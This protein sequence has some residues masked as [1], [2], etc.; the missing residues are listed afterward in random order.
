MP[1]KATPP[2]AGREAGWLD[3]NVEKDLLE[4]LN[5]LVWAKP[6]ERGL[7]PSTAQGL[8]SG[9][10]FDHCCWAVCSGDPLPAPRRSGW[11]PEAYVKPLEEAP[12]SPMNP[13][14]PVTPMNLMSP[15]NELPSRYLGGQKWA[16]V[17]TL[18]E[19]GPTLQGD[20]C[21]LQS[22]VG[23]ASFGPWRKGTP[24][25]HMRKSLH[26]SL[27]LLLGLPSSPYGLLWPRY[28]GG[29]CRTP[30]SPADGVGCSRGLTPDPLPVPP[31]SGLRSYP[32]RGSHSLDDLLDRPGNSAAPLEYWDGQARSRTPSRVPSCAPSPAPT[33]LPDSRRSSMGS[34]G[35]ASDV[36]VSPH[37]PVSSPGLMQWAGRLETR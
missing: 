26:P 14:S 22:C 1:P 12:V 27:C 9:V 4:G 35:V 3:L 29:G 11:F 7:A 17:G 2:L 32:L 18:V 33:P 6:A 37:T 20:I 36:K 16:R 25:T 28:K 30:R 31:S 8:L 5:E 13:L 34:P 15:M 24:P 19:G 10:G 23:P 21:E